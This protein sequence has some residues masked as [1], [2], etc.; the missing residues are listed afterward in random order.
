VTSRRGTVVWLG[1]GETAMPFV[2]KSLHCLDCGKEFIFTAGEQEFYAKKGFTNEPLRCKD[3]RDVRKR[4]REGSATPRE[5]FDAVCAKCGAGTQV[6]FRP[7]DDRP[8]Y[9][10]TCFREIRAQQRS[11]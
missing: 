6:P 7:R 3:C 8:V 1:L 9:C 10:Q 5:M 2:D 4:A 11:E